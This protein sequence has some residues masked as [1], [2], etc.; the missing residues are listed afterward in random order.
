MMPRTVGRSLISINAIK[1]I[2]LACPEVYLS[3]DSFV[4]PIINTNY[5]NAHDEIFIGI[6]EILVR[7]GVSSVLLFQHEDLSLDP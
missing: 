5:P 4:K 2:L 6:S 1:T 3:G 7:F